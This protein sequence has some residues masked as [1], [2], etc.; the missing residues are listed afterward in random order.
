MS[1][2][3]LCNFN[4]PG[5]RYAGEFGVGGREDEAELAESD[6][7]ASSRVVRLGGLGLFRLFSRYWH[8]SGRKVFVHVIQG[9]VPSQR[10]FLGQKRQ[11]LRLFIT[12]PL[13]LSKHAD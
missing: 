5:V 13:S 6:E 10:Y 9:K 2:Y 12:H 4:G 8:S 7:D 3:S 1:R 11:T